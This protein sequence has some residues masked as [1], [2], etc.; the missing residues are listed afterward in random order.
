MACSDELLLTD[1]RNALA[2]Q[3]GEGQ[4]RA[5]LEDGPVHF[6]VKNTGSTFYG[7]GFEMLQVLKDHSRP[8]SISNSFTTLLALLNNTQ[9]IKESI[10]K[11]W[12]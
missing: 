1:V 10:H 11:F 4:L 8:S 5:A 7:K 2:S 3:Y 6:L 9:S 12:S